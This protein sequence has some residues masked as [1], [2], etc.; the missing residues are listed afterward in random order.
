MALALQTSVLGRTPTTLQPDIERKLYGNQRTQ[1]NRLNGAVV[2]AATT[3]TMGFD[4]D[5]VRPG[6]YLEV[7]SELVFVWSVA[8][9]VAT[10]QRQMLGTTP[11]SHADQS[12]VRVEP[13]FLMAEM[14]DEIVKEIRS[15]PPN[16]YRRYVGD[17]SIGA[18]TNAIDVDGL[19][20][21]DNAQLLRVQV[22]PSTTTREKWLRVDGARIERRQNTTS[23]PSGYGLAIPSDLG[24]ARTLR[25]VARAPYS[26]ITLAAAADFGSLGLTN[27]LVDIIPWGVVGRLLLT[28]DVARTDANAQ[29]RSRPAEEV[30]PGDAAQIG[31]AMLQERD[32]MLND[33]SN[34]LMAED[35][36]GWM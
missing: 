1:L 14:L 10:V 29:G 4:M 35:G 23:F 20:G 24:T 25:V 13:R 32:R 30:R 2:T 33:A 3:M 5:G 31:R 22:N 36:M 11:T 21:V 15:W 7:D 28:R 27:D 17:L 12:I 16:I 9:Q 19:S 18:S 34:R 8:G 6:A 26:N